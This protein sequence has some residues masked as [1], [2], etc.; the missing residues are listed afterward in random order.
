M[1][2]VYEYKKEKEE[3]DP[4]DKITFLTGEIDEETAENIIKKIIKL[5]HKQEVPFI[6]MIINS[7][8]GHIPSGFAI[9]DIMRWSKI[10]IY[11]I[12]LGLIA[13]MGLLIF[14]AGEKGHRIITP[15]TSVLSHRFYAQIK[16]THSELLAFR[17]EEDFLY[18]RIINHYLEFSKIKTKTELEKKL[19]KDVEIWLTPEE[20]V[21]F[22]L[23]DIIQNDRRKIIN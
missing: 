11:T 20:T 18:K 4:L 3:K 9:I 12:G 22:G 21:K 16:G 23:A 1:S 5:N 6:Q 7:N 19:L 15:R 10:P 14:M 17:K 2:E 8:G 13:S